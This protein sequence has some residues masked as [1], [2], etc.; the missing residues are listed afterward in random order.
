MTT[1]PCPAGCG[2]FASLNGKPLFLHKGECGR[3]R[4]QAQEAEYGQ[5]AWE[6][7]QRRAARDLEGFERAFEVLSADADEYGLDVGSR[8]DWPNDPGLTTQTVSIREQVASLGRRVA[9]CARRNDLVNVARP[10]LDAIEELLVRPRAFIAPVQPEPARLVAPII[11]PWAIEL[12]LDR[13]R[14]CTPFGAALATPQRGDTPGVSRDR[15]LV[16]W[17]AALLEGDQ[18]TG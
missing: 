8:H 14:D 15:R 16:A 5:I 6:C 9:R 2:G 17:Y 3:R 4:R 10:L 12:A 7:R 18:H 11:L 1:E 13:L